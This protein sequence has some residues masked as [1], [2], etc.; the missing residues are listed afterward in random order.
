MERVFKSFSLE[1]IP[2]THSVCVCAFPWAFVIHAPGSEFD[3]IVLS[4]DAHGVSYM[5]DSGQVSRL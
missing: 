5:F 4:R 1:Y 2:C 3:H